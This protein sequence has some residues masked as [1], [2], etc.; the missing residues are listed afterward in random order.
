MIVTCPSCSA[1]YK[2]NESKIKGRSAK[3]TC[4]RCGHRFLFDRGGDEQGGAAVPA[5]DLDFSEVGITWKVRAQSGTLSFT[6]LSELESWLRDGTV[7]DIDQISFNDRKWYYIEQ[8]PDRARYFAEIHRKASRGE[9]DVG[10]GDEDEDEDDS[11]APTTIAGGRGSPGNSASAYATTAAPE[12]EAEEV[13]VV[14]EVADEPAPA[15]AKPV[16]PA[17]PAP[18]APAAAPK[19][20]FA[21]PASTGPDMTVVVGGVVAVAILAAAL[22]YFG[23]FLGGRS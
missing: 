21:P 18:A 3:I 20:P 9:L 15:P 19:A 6:R 17:A 5:A 22:A 4:P 1:R 13:S 23:G 7:E 2:V 16:A 11:D 8:I 14:E 12:S 10:G